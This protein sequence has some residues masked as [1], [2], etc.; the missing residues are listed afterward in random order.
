MGQCRD[1]TLDSANP[2]NRVVGSQRITVKSG[3]VDLEFLLETSILSYQW[4]EMCMA[5]GFYSTDDI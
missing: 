1:C 3:T 5:S 2:V 4:S